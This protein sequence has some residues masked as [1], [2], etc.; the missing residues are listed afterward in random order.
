LSVETKVRRKRR[1]LIVTSHPGDR[2]R[3]LARAFHAR[4]CEAWVTPLEAVRFDS[5]AEYGLFVPG[6]G[7]TLPDAVLVCSM[8][9]GTFEAVTRR[10][11]ILHALGELGVLVWS[12]PVSRHPPPSRLK[13]WMRR[14][15]LLSE[16]CQLGPWC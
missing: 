7:S 9:G 12:R 15:K 13:A 14:A 6:F 16:S 1:I 4:G 8:G 2:S 10:L 5:T 11:G 3:T